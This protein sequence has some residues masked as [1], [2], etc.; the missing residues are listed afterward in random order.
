MSETIGLEPTNIISQSETENQKN[1]I[2]L[3]INPK[4]FVEIIKSTLLNEETKNKISIKLTPEIINIINKIISLTP[5]TFNDIE[6]AAVQI[7]KD[8]K[9]DSNDIPQFIVVVQRIYQVVYSFKD[10]KIDAK[11]RSEFTATIL[12]FVIHLLV[13]ERKI[14]ID[15]DK[16]EEFLKN[17]DILIDSCIGLL[18]FPKSLKTKGCLKKIFG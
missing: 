14:K 7:I 12:K 13:Q 8:G 5:D 17:C 1:Y 9:I 15:N 3:D 4:N 2:V 18:S 10:T 11:K 6:K 16:Q